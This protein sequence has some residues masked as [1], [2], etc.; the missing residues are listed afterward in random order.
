MHVF[1]LPVVDNEVSPRSRPSFGLPDGFV[2]L[3]SFDFF[4]IFERKNP[5]AVIEAFKLAFAPGEGP[6]LVVKS[7]NGDKNLPQLER[8]RYAAASR[9]D[10]RVVDGYVSASERERAHGV[11]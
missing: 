7:I 4:S 3:F 8:L 1:P 9:P 10:I 2:F 11:M 5:L 6:V